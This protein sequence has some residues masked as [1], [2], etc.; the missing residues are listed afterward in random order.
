MKFRGTSKIVTFYTRRYGK[1]KGVAKGARETKS[2]FGASLE[3]MTLVSLVL[4][5][6]EHRD[7]QLISQAD[8]LHRHKSIHSDFDRMPVALSVIE[9]LNRLTHEEEENSLLYALVLETLDAIDRAP[10]NAVNVLFAFELRVC[11]LFGFAPALDRCVACGRS[12]EGLE[13]KGVVLQLPRG[14]VYCPACSGPIP[15]F[16]PERLLTVRR[17]HHGAS[18]A[19]ERAG[20]IR[21]SMPALQILRRLASANLAGVT[22]LE[23]NQEVGNELEVTLRLYLRYHFEEFRPLRSLK[24]FH[25]ALK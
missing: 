9:L 12:L 2:K 13:G 25:I 23:Y 4:Y 22:G 17:S 24:M 16:D 20:T 19:A 15:V 10:R 5:K 8:I 21:L 1:L 14:A 6:K 18:E 3:P 11:S 7:L